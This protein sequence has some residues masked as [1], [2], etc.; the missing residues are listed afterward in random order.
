MNQLFLKS[1]SVL[2]ISG[3]FF[4]A[5]KKSNSK[6]NTE[7]LTQA[8][9]KFDHATATGYGDISAQIPACYKDNITSFVSNGTGTIDESAN[10]CS[11]S[12]A[13]SFT[14]NFLTNET[15]LHLSTVLFTGG[16]TDFNIVALNANNLV[17]SQMVTIAPLPATTVEFTF[18]H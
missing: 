6:S 2:L 16:T 9:W 14:W 10:V 13:G 17:I 3:L 5:C 1:L 15:V 11:P 18:K 12:T 7:L 4:C 8:A